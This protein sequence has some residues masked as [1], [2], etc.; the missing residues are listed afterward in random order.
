L[1]GLKRVYK[2]IIDSG[3]KVTTLLNN[4]KILE[5]ENSFI[6][7]LKTYNNAWLVANSDLLQV[8]F[9]NMNV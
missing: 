4:L 6:Q 8:L 1:S 9:Q 7:N 5:D 3:L 2:E